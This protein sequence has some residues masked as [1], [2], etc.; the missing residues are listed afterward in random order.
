MKKIA[1]ILLL[2]GT[3]SFATLSIST[4][5]LHNH[6]IDFNDHYNCP[7]FI[8]NATF[9]SMVFVFIAKTFIEFPKLKFKILPEKVVFI[10]TRK[11]QSISNRAPPF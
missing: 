4:P 11:E 7:A 9:V 2:I 6:Q 3:L 8:L 1:K 5:L 10:S